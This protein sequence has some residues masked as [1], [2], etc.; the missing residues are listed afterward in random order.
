MAKLTEHQQRMEAGLKNSRQQEA[1]QKF[2]DAYVVSRENAFAQMDLPTLRQQIADSKDAALQDR[3]D[4]RR[5]FCVQAEQ[6]GAIIYHAA[7]A[8]DANR[9]IA[10]LA[11]RNGVKQIVKSKSMVTEEMHLNDYLHATGS[12]A[13]EV[14]ETDL[15][16][17]IVQLAD[18]RP[19]HMVMPAIH[20]FRDEVAKLFTAQTG[21]V[22]ADDIEHLVK[23]ARRQLRKAFLTADMGI[24]GANVAIAE[25]GSIALVTNEGNARLVT[26]LPKIQVAVV[27]IEKIVPTLDDAA[28]ILDALPRN[29]TGQQ[30]TSYV[31]WLRGAVPW[32]GEPKEFHIVL[33]DNGRAKLA[34]D[35]DCSEA[36]RCIRCGACANVCPVYQ[37]V[38]G[39]AFGHIYIGAIG[40]ILTAFQNGID[41]AQGIIDSCIGCRSC[42]EVCPSKID[43]EKIILRLRQDSADSNGLPLS[44]N[45]M[46]RKVMRNRKLFHTLLRTAS[47]VQKPLVDG[48]EIRHLPLHFSSFTDWRTLPAIAATPFRDVVS[49][50]QKNADGNGERQNY[51][52][53]VAFFAGCATDFIYPELGSALF[54]VLTS[55]NVQMLFPQQQNCCGI[56]ALYSGDKETVVELAK[57]N[58]K[59]L[60]ADRPDYVLSVCPTCTGALK[61]HFVQVL[62][63]DEEWLPQ[64]EQL[65]AVT[66]DA[67][68]FLHDVLAISGVGA[69]DGLAKVTYHDSCHLKRGNGVWQQPRALLQDGGY[70]LT[71]ME[72]S[73]RCCGFGGSYSFTGQPQVAKKIT[74]GKVNA[75]EQT[76]AAVVA[77]D[78]PGC[79][80][81]LR[82]ALSKQGSKV[83]AR[84]TIELLADSLMN[85]QD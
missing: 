2:A 85:S 38:G 45:I 6:A 3:E 39:H 13:M 26:T 15:G 44:K 27:G 41:T 30:L 31:T 59:A 78:C 65:A 7:T 72:R 48:G 53:R 20:M 64:A 50:L 55:E 23:V 71:E 76:A 29:A 19:S 61:E 32:H 77:M 54:K 8:E 51:R 74:A 18:Q 11:E 21:Q 49:A 16:E 9:Y 25:N 14:M 52:Y 62:K 84:H 17:W 69:G 57:Q 73:D 22:E 28:L 42:V 68:Q 35:E 5:R 81:M 80:I 34:Q 75:I 12:G 47:K 56:P 33:I 83:M 79:L 40:I 1:L 36:L 70:Q 58:I 82:G 66:M 4:L 67:A 10:E 37:T 46:F 63:N 43:L 24:T 60:L